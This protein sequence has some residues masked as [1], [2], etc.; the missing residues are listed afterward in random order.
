MISRVYVTSTSRIC[1][2]IRKYI[3]F[4]VCVLAWDG[5]GW[6]IYVNRDALIRQKRPTYTSQIRMQMLF[7]VYVVAWDGAVWYIYVNRDA[8]IRQKRP[9]Y[10]SYMRRICG[11]HIYITNTW[12]TVHR[13][14]WCI[15][16]IHIYDV[17]KYVCRSC[18]TALQSQWIVVVMR[19]TIT[20]WLQTQFI[21][22]VKRIH[23][24][25]FVYDCGCI[26]IVMRF[27]YTSQIRMQILFDVYVVAWDGAVWFMFVNRD[28]LIRQ[29]R[30]IY[31]SQTRMQILFDVY[32]VAWDG[33]VIHIR[34]QRCSYTPKETHIYATNTYADLVWRIRSGLRWHWVVWVIS[35]KFRWNGPNVSCVKRF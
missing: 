8:L 25:R 32:V 1:S 18:L 6:F 3:W 11:S 13:N 15:Y 22:I 28:A 2:H 17:H 12:C 24:Y 10:T 5:D 26:V 16:G 23:D 7:D 34:Q 4:A 19:F 31:T 29:K 20:M 14:L 27:T 30:P 21:V 33:T 35:T 9:T